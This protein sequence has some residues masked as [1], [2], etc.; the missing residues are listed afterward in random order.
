MT[1]RLLPGTK[2]SLIPVRTTGYI[3]RESAQTTVILGILRDLIATRG[4]VKV[5]LIAEYG[6]DDSI[7]SAAQAI[8]RL[9]SITSPAFHARAGVN[10]AAMNKHLR[11]NLRLVK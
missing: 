11:W 7:C 5:H 2:V 10:Y 4:N 9:E 1:A 8:N 6:P 3:K